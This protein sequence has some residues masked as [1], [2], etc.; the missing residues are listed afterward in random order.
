[1]W[2]AL[3][4]LWIVAIAAFV[5]RWYLERNSLVVH[6]QPV[7]E[8]VKIDMVRVAG[9]SILAIVR[10]IYGKPSRERLGTAVEFISAGTYQNVAV[11]LAPDTVDVEDGI[12]QGDIVYAVIY[13]A[14]GN[15][16]VPQSDMWG[17][18][19]AYPFRLN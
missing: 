15:N 19:I 2:K 10:S 6:Y 12:T 4:L 7:G 16:E 8:I 9:P 13:T 17:R 11:P 1:M 5:G 3:V 18:Q 14:R